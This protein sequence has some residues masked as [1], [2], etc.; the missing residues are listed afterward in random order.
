MKSPSGYF[1]G[2]LLSEVVCLES[3]LEREEYIPLFQMKELETQIPELLSIV[4]EW[5]SSCQPSEVK[6]RN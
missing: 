4:T 2:S 3:S 1:Y 6:G 5:V